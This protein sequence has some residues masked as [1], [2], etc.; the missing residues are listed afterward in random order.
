[1]S[2]ECVQSAVQCNVE[3]LRI[4]A[5]VILLDREAKPLKQIIHKIIVKKIQTMMVWGF[6]AF[7]CVTLTGWK[8]QARGRSSSS[9]VAQIPSSN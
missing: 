2:S 6:R 9:S 7:F 5:A 1:M 8:N 4:A 3:M